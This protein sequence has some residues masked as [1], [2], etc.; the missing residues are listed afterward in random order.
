MIHKPNPPFNNINIHIQKHC[1]YY[2]GTISA[3]LRLTRVRSL[4][5]LRGC[6]HMKSGLHG[7]RN[8]DSLLHLLCFTVFCSL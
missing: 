4:S 6:L 5:S 7:L 3:V 1:G 2:T 8:E